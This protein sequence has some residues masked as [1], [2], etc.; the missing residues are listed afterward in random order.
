MEVPAIRQAVIPS[1]ADGLARVYVSSAAHHARLDPGFYRVPPLD[2]VAEQYRSGRAGRRP[3]LLLAELDDRII[4]MAVLTEQ[5][6]P[7]LASMIAPTRT[8]SV[9]VAVL[10]E[11]RGQGVGTL[12]MLAVEQAARTQ[13]VRRLILD[14][15]CANDEALRFY[16]VRLG[17]QDQGILLRK[18]LSDPTQ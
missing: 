1:D 15:A 4:G 13:R 11:H 6:L 8:A 3:D 18:D 2:A 5:A 16:R 9:D 17:Y 7:G 10:D 14:A 12:L